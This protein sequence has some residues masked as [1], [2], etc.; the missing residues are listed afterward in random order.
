MHSV[1]IYMTDLAYG[2]TEEG[3]WWYTSGFPSTDHT[4]HTKY[5][6]NEEEALKYSTELYNTVCKELNEGR[7]SV[8]SVL[9]NGE[10]DTQVMDGEPRPFPDER[11]YYS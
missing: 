6:D 11:P 10:Y 8:S 1:A 7:A 5:F 2:G 3:G 9:S 4:E